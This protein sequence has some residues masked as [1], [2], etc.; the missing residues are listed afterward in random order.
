MLYI[1]SLVHSSELAFTQKLKYQ[2]PQPNN[3]THQRL[4]N[5]KTTKTTLLIF[6]LTF[7]IVFSTTVIA[8]PVKAQNTSVQTIVLSN[9]QIGLMLLGNKGYVTLSIYDTLVKLQTDSNPS[10]S[11]VISSQFLGTLHSLPPSS[12]IFTKT[13]GNYED[14]NAIAIS[15]D[16][17]VQT[18]STQGST[19]LNAPG[20]SKL[21]TQISNVANFRAIYSTSQ[22]PIVS[23][24][25]GNTTYNVFA[26]LYLPSDAAT[27][28]PTATSPPV[29][30][31]PTTPE[32]PSIILLPLALAMLFAVALIKRKSQKLNSSNPTT[33]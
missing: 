18:V 29:T 7:I 3:Q 5:L 21:D 31:T 33:L 19:Y 8:L 4:S 1:Q 11:G 15:T 28:N 17:S 20:T 10:L 12:Q 24:T 23:F 26:I 2:Q 13:L 30:N 6:T 14:W 27:I 32:F 16:G 9:E 25:N 22:T